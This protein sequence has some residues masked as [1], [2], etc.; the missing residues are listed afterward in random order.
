MYYPNLCDSS[1]HEGKMTRE[2]NELS[3]T[4]TITALSPTL[5]CILTNNKFWSGSQYMTYQWSVKAVWGTLETSKKKGHND[6]GL[7]HVNWEI[8][9]ETSWIMKEYKFWP[10]VVSIHH[11]SMIYKHTTFVSQDEKKHYHQPGNLMYIEMKTK[12]G[13]WIMNLAIDIL[14]PRGF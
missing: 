10:C 3:I 6:V 2:R 7:I 8:E 14:V 12:G 9:N 1:S 4:A 5:T 11:L 13:T